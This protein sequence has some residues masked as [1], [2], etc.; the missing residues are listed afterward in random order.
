MR[1]RWGKNTAGRQHQR[2][3]AVMLR[4]IRFQFFFLFGLW[5]PTGLPCTLRSLSPCA[6][7]DLRRIFR[8]ALR[9]YPSLFTTYR[10]VATRLEFC[11]L[12]RRQATKKHCVWHYVSVV[13]VLATETETDRR[14]KYVVER[15]IYS[16]IYTYVILYV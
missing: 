7:F 14:K 16:Y 5:I 11:E 12:N 6:K 1:Q 9:R 15:L 4:P 2:W 10:H 3:R 13:F 8:S